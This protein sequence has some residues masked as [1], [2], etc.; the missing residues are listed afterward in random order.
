MKAKIYTL[1][2]ILLLALSFTANADEYGNQYDQQQYGGQSSQGM[3][4]G[5]Q[6]YQYSRAQVEQQQQLIN[7]QRQQMAF[8]VQQQ[9]MSGG[10]YR[11]NNNRQSRNNNDLNIGDLLG[12]FK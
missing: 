9:Q 6:G 5:D 3:T 12:L 8:L 10:V 7:H 11:E 4:Y 2:A 1:I